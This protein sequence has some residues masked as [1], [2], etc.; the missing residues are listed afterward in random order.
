MHIHV[1]AFRNLD[2]FDYDVQD[3]KVNFLYGVCGSGK[4]SLLDALA[5]SPDEADATVGYE[6]KGPVVLVDSKE[7]TYEKY[8]IYNNQTHGTLFA[9]QANSESYRIF[10][11]DANELSVLEE[12]YDAMLSRLDTFKESVLSY[13][14][15]I[16]SAKKLVGSPK[17]GTCKLTGTSKFKK[18]GKMMREANDD[19][20][21]QVG[22]ISQSHLK[23]IIDGFKNTDVEEAWI[24]PFCNVKISEKDRRR[25]E[26]MKEMS[27]T[28]LAPV[29]EAS[30]V[31]VDLGIKEPD[32]SSEEE[33]E[34]AVKA[35]ESLLYVEQDLNRLQNL[36][37]QPKRL[38]TLRKDYKALELRDETLK[39]FPGLEDVVADI[40]AQDKKIR[41]LLGK[42]NSAANRVIDSNKKDLNTK[43]RALGIPYR[44][45]LNN[46]DYDRAEA[47]YVLEHVAA[48]ESGKDKVDMRNKLS[49]G[50]KNLVALLLFLQNRDEDVLLIDD[51]ASSFDDYRRTQIFK[52]IIGVKDKTVIVAT[53]DQAFIRLA[54]RR[55]NKGSNSIGN[56]QMIERHKRGIRLVDITKDSFVNLGA[57]ILERVEM[58]K[59]P[60]Q[61]AINAR[62]YVDLL[63]GS[64]C[65]VVW[66]YTSSLMHRMQANEITD[67]L[68]QRQTNEKEV[69]KTLDGMGVHL[70][71]ATGDY[72]YSQDDLSEFEMLVIERENLNDKEDINGLSEDERLK[73]E[74]LNDLVHMNNA[75]EH[76]LNPYRYRTWSSNLNE[77]L[78]DE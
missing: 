75:M 77:L 38:D 28:T 60:Y 5:S 34:E 21:T 41:E 64:A 3:G 50:E 59:S 22:E 30:N 47:S 68:A 45:N 76:C 7:P 74:M 17:P 49:F 51:P 14:A 20:R 25:L 11:G 57:A 1:E 55:R 78:L 39:R 10:V 27:A 69:L 53:H 72:H 18:A 31:L 56:V 26:G 9:E 70:E 23:W 12:E 61:A 48:T 16:E 19:I 36:I 42:M 29:F 4:S 63:G 46:A 71:P 8:A 6:G 35:F 37:N 33:V 67:W 44:F 73:K 32:W 40:N 66:G 58:S 13:K 54:A 62:L 15:Q 24:C 65:G 2:S 43:L 52:E